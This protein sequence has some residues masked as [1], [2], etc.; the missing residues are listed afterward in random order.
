MNRET[1]KFLVEILREQ[2]PPEETERLRKL[3]RKAI[4][5][6]DWI[7]KEGLDDED[8]RTLH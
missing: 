6:S 5:P 3:A 7:R 8:E 2:I 1:R 4:V